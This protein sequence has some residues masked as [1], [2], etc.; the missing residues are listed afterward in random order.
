M[1]RE[2]DHYELSVDVHGPY[3]HDTVNLTAKDEESLSPQFRMVGAVRFEFYENVDDAGYVEVLAD[4]VVAR[5]LRVIYRDRDDGV[6]DT[7]RLP[8]LP[9][10]VGALDRETT[11]E[12]R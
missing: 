9:A 4:H 8:N 3:Y 2:V 6:E 11:K 5:E 12:D 10:M 7:R 1:S